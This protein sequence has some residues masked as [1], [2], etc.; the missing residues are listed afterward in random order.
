MF[1][2]TRKHILGVAG[3]LAMAI[4]FAGSV[5][6]SP[7]SLVGGS[8][9]V[10]PSGAQQT[11]FN[12][13]PAIP[14]I[15]AGTTSVVVGATLNLLVNAP[16]LRYT[17]LGKEAGA[18]N[19]A[20]S[21]LGSQLFTNSAVAGT[22]ADVGPV[23]AQSPL[24]FSF[25]TNFGGGA[26][27]T[28]GIPSTNPQLAFYLPSPSSSIVYAFLDD[29]GFGDGPLLVPGCSSGDCDFDDMIISIQVVPLPAAAWLL[30][31]GL[32]GLGFVARRR[33]A[34]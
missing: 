28:N 27:V 3:A 1:G 26:T 13:T 11:S 7:W 12:P 8:S 30:I 21:F 18:S 2:T 15:V 19:A 9:Q 14:G 29:G 25:T 22:S 23:S 16:A 32:G 24:A 33:K 10:L 31:A 17:Y 20:F 5:Q 34:A 6:A 4:G